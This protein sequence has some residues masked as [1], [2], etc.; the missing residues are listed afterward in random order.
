MAMYA[1]SVSPLVFLFLSSM[2]RSG[3]GEQLKVMSLNLDGNAGVD[4]VVNLIKSVSAD[5]TGVQVS[6]A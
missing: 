6:G 5:I 3:A 4:T 2:L 1:R